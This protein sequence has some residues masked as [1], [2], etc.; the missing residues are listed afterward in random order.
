MVS[1]TSFYAYVGDSLCQKWTLILQNVT[2]YKFQNTINSYFLM[3]QEV[4]QRHLSLIQIN[5]VRKAK[6]DIFLFSFIRHHEEMRDACKKSSQV[7]FSA[8][9]L[10]FLSTWGKQEQEWQKDINT[11]I[12]DIRKKKSL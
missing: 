2:L 9:L 6:M 12:K 11:T 4:E 3:E 1:Q 7:F 8:V 5:N 10:S